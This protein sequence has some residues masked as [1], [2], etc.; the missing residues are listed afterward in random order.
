MKIIEVINLQGSLFFRWPSWRPI[1]PT[2][3]TIKLC[4]FDKPRMEDLSAVSDWVLM[5]NPTAATK[6][7]VGLKRKCADDPINEQI[8]TLPMQITPSPI[9]TTPTH[10]NE[11]PT[12]SFISPDALQQ[13]K[14]VVNRVD[15][16]LQLFQGMIHDSIKYCNMH[17]GPLQF[18]Y[19][20]G[21]HGVYLIKLPM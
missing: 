19:S 13:E 2:L 3:L 17:N 5:I 18:Q 16:N 9:S 20:S 12:L 8:P 21:K 10:P 6:M 15:L 7:S 14:R 1:S 11:F 4:S